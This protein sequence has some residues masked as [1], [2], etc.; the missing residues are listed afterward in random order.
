MK[1]MLGLLGVLATAAVVILVLLLDEPRVA[2]QA[3]GEET[4]DNGFASQ[5][6]MLFTP[7]PTQ[8]SA[9]ITPEPPIE[10]QILGAWMAMRVET[11]SKKSKELQVDSAAGGFRTVIEFV[12]D[13]TAVIATDQMTGVGPEA[14]MR[15]WYVLGDDVFIDYG[16]EIVGEEIYYGSTRFFLEDD[17]LYAVY[18]LDGKEVSDFVVYGRLTIPEDPAATPDASAQPDDGLVAAL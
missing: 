13:G 18:T 5:Q 15:D 11:N 7:E 9:T 14:A 12:P 2:V 6:W 3:S 10:E 4:F 1:V 17:L 8:Y 16:M